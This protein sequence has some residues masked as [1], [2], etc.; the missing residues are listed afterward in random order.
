MLND[1]LKPELCFMNSLKAL[2]NNPAAPVNILE[3]TPFLD[4]I[5][6]NRF[7]APWMEVDSAQFA[8]KAAASLPSV[9]PGINLRRK[10]YS[11]EKPW[12]ETPVDTTCAP[13]IC[14]AAPLTEETTGYLASDIDQC[15]SETWS[16]EESQFDNLNET[17]N[18]R[19]AEMLRRKA[20]NI[21]QKVNKISLQQLYASLSD[22]SDG[23][24]SIGATTKRVNIITSDMKVSPVGLAK[25]A[26]EY[27]RES[28][29]GDYVIFG[30]HTLA[31][32]WQVRRWQMSPEGRLGSDLADGSLPFI[33]DAAFDPTFQTLE[34]DNASHGV[35]VPI[36][37]F[38]I[39]FWNEF[40]GYKIKSFED[41][42]K[43]TIEI[44]GVLFDYSLFYDKCNGKYTEQL[45]LHFGF[46]ALP[47]SIY[48]SGRALIKHWEFGCGDVDCDTLCSNC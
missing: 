8:G 18:A 14:E 13:N 6:Q 3:G 10:Y 23:T 33:Y 25:I 1:I 34:A 28:F 35:T 41:F 11:Y 24:A 16:V 9:N 31:D 42:I 26:G 15:I 47:D 30:G 19:R 45:K 46:L 43:T 12:C 29:Q 20:W 36:G 48:C 39:D 4:T 22:Y 38:A 5:M 32:F 27:R 21:R 37:S 2:E 7:M 40:T 17:P 44:D